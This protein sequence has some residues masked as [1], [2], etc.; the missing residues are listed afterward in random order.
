MQ[1]QCTAQPAVLPG[2]RREQR[3]KE[4]N[5]FAGELSV[6]PPQTPQEQGVSHGILVF[7]LGFEWGAFI[8][9]LSIS[10]ALSQ[11]VLK[12]RKTGAGGEPGFVCFWAKVGQLLGRKSRKHQIL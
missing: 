1:T 6:F 5:N 11:H 8:D 3:C 12:V 2:W 4:G 7:A 9:I 10:A